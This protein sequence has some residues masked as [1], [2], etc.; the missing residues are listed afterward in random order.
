MMNFDR[1]YLEEDLFPREIAACEERPYGYL[2]HNEDN[3]DSFDSNHALILR[4]G[5][6]DAQA[7]L[8]D[9][10]VFYQRRGIRPCLYQSIREE[11]YFEEIGGA[12]SACG[13]DHWTERQRY[14]ILSAG[15]AIVPDPAIDVQRVGEWR[16][17]YAA[18]VF[19][20]AGEPWETAVARRA[21][22]NGN[23]LF[24]VAHCDGRPVG[25]THAHITQGIC[26]VDYLLVAKAYR[27]MGVGRALISA[28]VTHCRDN[29]V[30]DCYLWPDGETAERIYHE[31]GFRHAETK[32]AG[33]A[34][35]RER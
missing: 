14:M 6:Q 30:K 21:L 4:A 1:M 19:E 31:A 5:V 10:T 13:F 24:F 7:V 15:N 27:G 2:F 18:D 35:L 34:V 16:D 28:F 25:M 22:M 8:R 26:R 11:G 29:H 12:L 17:A 3:R 20:A 33:R 9:M 23:T 32:L